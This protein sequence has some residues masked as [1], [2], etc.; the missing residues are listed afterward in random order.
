MNGDRC[1]LDFK[2]G[3]LQSER[4]CGFGAFRSRQTLS[5]GRQLREEFFD[6]ENRRTWEEAADID[7]AGGKTPR[8]RILYCSDGATVN[9][10]WELDE[11]SYYLRRVEGPF[12]CPVP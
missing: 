7:D 10:R 2:D 11:A 6:G 4:R 9:E 12:E 5:E 8:T 3:V 1:V